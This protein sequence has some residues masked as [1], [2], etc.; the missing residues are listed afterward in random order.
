VP[1]VGPFITLVTAV[2]PD[3]PPILQWDREDKRNPV[4]WYVQSGGALASQYGLDSGEWAKVT[5]V[6]LFPHQWDVE[7][8][9]ANHG[10]GA[11]FLLEGAVNK[12][13]DCL[14]LFP[15][16]LRSELHGIRSVIERHQITGTLQGKEEASA[17]GVDLRAWNQTFR[18]KLAGQSGTFDYL[19]D[20]WD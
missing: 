6:C 20:R 16:C 4:S 7:R 9:Y 10:K 11:I 14:G 5:A 3:A 18:V 8:E 13:G 15:E 1:A 19:I 17:C 12:R 2:Y